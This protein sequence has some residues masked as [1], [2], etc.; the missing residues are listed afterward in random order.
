MTS[1]TVPVIDI[2]EI[3]NPDTLAELDTA[4]PRGVQEQRVAPGRAA[5]GRARHQ[6]RRHP[7][8][9]VDRSLLRRPVSRYREINWG[10]FRAPRAEGDYADQRE[11]IQI[12]HYKVSA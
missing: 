11:E 12:E 4:R 1:N 5:P 2:N 8:G 9:L 3:N 10:E 7:A 6:H